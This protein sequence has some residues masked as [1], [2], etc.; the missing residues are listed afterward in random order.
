MCFLAKQLARE[1][2]RLE[3]YLGRDFTRGIQA[4]FVFGVSVLVLL[5]SYRVF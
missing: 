1:P 3:I 4:V 2:Q 5:E